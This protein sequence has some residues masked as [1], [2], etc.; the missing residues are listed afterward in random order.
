M[1]EEPYKLKFKFNSILINREST[2]SLAD[3]YF[4][5]HFDEI[6]HRIYHTLIFFLIVSSI[7]FSKMKFLVKILEKPVSSIQFF[8]LSPG[9]YFFSTLIIAIYTGLIFCTPFVLGQTVFFFGPALRQLEKNIIIYLLINS[10]LLFLL[11]LVFSYFILIPAAL[12]FFILYA[13][14]V[15]EPF[16]SF[17]EYFSFVS[18]LFFSTALVFQIPIIQ[19][20]LSLFKVFNPRDTLKYWRAILLFS[21]ILG[22]VLTPS[23]DPVTQLLLSSAL[24]FLYFLG[25][26]ISISLTKSYNYLV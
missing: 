11:G 25:T 6:K 24:F 5:E 26:F 18:T 19:I 15:L 22:A 3:L 21:T 1:E 9:E 2:R 20:L 10:V 13:S 23:A 7:S 14:E 12:N 17:N 16:L 8:Q 4:K